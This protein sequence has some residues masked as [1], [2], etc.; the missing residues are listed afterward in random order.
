MLFTGFPKKLEQLESKGAFWKLKFKINSEKI[1]YRF[2]SVLESELS[3][4]L[5]FFYIGAKQ[6][7]GKVHL[8]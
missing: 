7:Y 8:S 6:T 2:C 3:L 5:I 4:L 1:Q